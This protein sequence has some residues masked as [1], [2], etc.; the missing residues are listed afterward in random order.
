M[1]EF[2]AAIYPEAG[3]FPRMRLLV[4]G[5][6]K[7]KVEYVGRARERL[8]EGLKKGV[9]MWDEDVKDRARKLVR[10]KSNEITKG[11]L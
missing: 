1:V 2:D 9:D 5:A 10:S 7:G 8:V 6:D 3:G 4:E 11:P